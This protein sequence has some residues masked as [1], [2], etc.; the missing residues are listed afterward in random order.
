VLVNQ[1]TPRIGDLY[2]KL[3]YNVTELTAPR[4]ISCTGDRTPA[5]EIFATR[6]LR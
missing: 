2:R 3:G 5:R 6:N 4:R 1:F